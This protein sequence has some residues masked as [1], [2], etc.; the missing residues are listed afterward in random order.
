[1]GTQCF[2]SSRPDS[3]NQPRPYTDASLRHMKYGKVQPM[4]SD[5]PGFIARLL[6]AR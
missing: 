5:Q 3:W 4:E 1:M 6:G 2:R